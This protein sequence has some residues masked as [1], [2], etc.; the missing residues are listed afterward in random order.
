MHETSDDGPVGVDN[1]EQRNTVGVTSGEAVVDGLIGI[2]GYLHRVAVLLPEGSYLVVVL[3]SCDA[4]DDRTARVLVLPLLD[5]GKPFVAVR[6]PGVEEEDDG[7]M[8]SDGG[9]GDGF[10][11]GCDNLEGTDLVALQDL[12]S[13]LDGVPAGDGCKD[14]CEEN[15]TESVSHGIFLLVLIVLNL[16]EVGHLS[17]VP[18]DFTGL[19]R[20]F[21][22]FALERAAFAFVVL[23]VGCLSDGVLDTVDDDTVF[24]GNYSK[25]R[26][27]LLSL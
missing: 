18:E 9:V 16:D 13:R 15:N 1:I 5:D 11:V 6:A 23:R 26:F 7:V 14:Y 25:T 21:G 17:E 20:Q 22:A 2:R 3:S 19:H 24:H 27:N 4:E 10:P 12:G 8:S